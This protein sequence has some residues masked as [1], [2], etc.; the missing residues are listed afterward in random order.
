MNSNRFA[1]QARRGSAAVYLLTGLALGSGASVLAQ[2]PAQEPEEG[3]VIVVTGSRIARDVTDAST[4]IAIIDSDEIKLSGATSIDKVL[5]DQPQFVAATNGG[6]TANTVPAGSAA[7][8]AYVN[9]RGFG[10]TR[11][12]TLVN[13]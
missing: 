13:G 8:A 7:G 9:L 2:E 4:P 12:L 5:N 6:A 3:D 11:S 10:P 1:G